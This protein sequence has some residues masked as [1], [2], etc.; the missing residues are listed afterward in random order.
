MARRR[1]KPRFRWLKFFLEVLILVILAAALFVGYKLVQI[2]RLNVTQEEIAANENIPVEE[3]GSMTGYQTL[4]LFGVDS[5]EGALESGT[6]SDTIMVCA[7]NKKTKEVK[8]VSIYRD[9]YLDAGGGDYRKAT[10]AYAIGG[11]QQSISMLNRNLDLNI[12]DYVTVNFD[13]LVEI[14]DLFGGVDINLSEGEVQWLNGYLVEARQVL[15]RESMDVPG[16]GMQHLNGMQALAYCRIRYIGLD[17]ERTQRQRTV[18]SQVMEKA[19]GSSIFRLNEALDTILPKISTSLS[20]TELLTLAASA[21]SYTMGETQ[22]FP[23]NKAELTLSGAGDCVV[24]VDLAANVSELHA[25]LYGS[26]SY[27]PSLTVQEISN[28][29]AYNTGAY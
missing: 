26:E 7:I 28:T 10:E 25:F 16:P 21:G 14:V 20:V 11:V 15:G 23:Y 3:L 6:N 1:K 9:T 27:L 22:G 13:A 18:L 8:L 2:K 24:P 19:K 12:T 4:A 17:Y 29:I 5:R